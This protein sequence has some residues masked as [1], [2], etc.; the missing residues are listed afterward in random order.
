MKTK[1]FNKKEVDLQ[2]Q[3]SPFMTWI[4]LLNA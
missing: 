2:M 3:F 4:D 1:I